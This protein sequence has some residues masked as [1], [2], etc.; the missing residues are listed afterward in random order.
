MKAKKKVPVYAMEW[1]LDALKRLYSKTKRP[2]E[3][4]RLAVAAETGLCAHSPS[5]ALSC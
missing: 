2:T 1:Q 3:D 5:R 4:Q